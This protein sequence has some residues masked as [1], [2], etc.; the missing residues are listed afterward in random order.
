LFPIAL[1]GDLPLEDKSKNELVA[2]REQQVK[3]TRVKRET[4]TGSGSGNESSDESK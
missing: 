3:E 1:N 2:L 4:P